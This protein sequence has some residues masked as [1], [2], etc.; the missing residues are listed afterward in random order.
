MQISIIIPVFNERN[1]I[2]T[3]IDQVYKKKI[4]GL[5][6]EIIV[7]DN[8]SNDGTKEILKELE[9]NFS[10]IKFLYQDHNFGKGSNIKNALKYA[11][12]EYCLIQDAD[13][14]YSPDDYLDFIKTASSKKI[15]VIFGTR[16]SRAKEFHVYSY[17][18]LIANR[19]ITF[20]INIIFNKSFSD[21]LTGYKFIKTEMTCC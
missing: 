11:T 9:N 21:V 15:E 4:E 17:I 10:D 6:L 8:N 5:N 19:I 3:C 12:G 18:H 20:I 2:K 13:L 14:E 7:S 1:S 16:F